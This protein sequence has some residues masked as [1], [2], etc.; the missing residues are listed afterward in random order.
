MEEAVEPRSTTASTTPSGRRSSSRPSP[1]ASAD[2]P[3]PSPSGPTRAGTR[4][5]RSS[6]LVLTP[7]SRSPA[8]RS[9]TTCRRA[10]SRAR[11]RST[12]RRRRRTTVR[13]RS[14]RRSCPRARSSFRSGSGSRSF[15]MA[16]SS[17]TSRRR[18]PGST[19][20]STTCS[21]PR[22]G[23]VVPAR[24]VP[25]HRHGHRRGLRVQPERGRRLP[26]RD[27]RARSSR[28][29]RRVGRDSAQA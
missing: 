17:S 2:P 22:P 28:E 27:G 5:S 18:P 4:R 24:R 6:T 13:A 16:P 23:A 10:R 20:R 25:A 26:D 7:G 19:G 15:A 3:S 1:G 8:T 12:C 11:T 9:A 14:G 29:P 21:K